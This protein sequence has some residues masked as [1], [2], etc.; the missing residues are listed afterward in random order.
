MKLPKTIQEKI[1]TQSYTQD[2]IGMSG[3]TILLFDTMVLKI[4]P[5]SPE[6][7]T[8]YN[9]LHWLGGRLPV[10]DIL[11]HEVVDGTSYLLMSRLSGQMTCDLAIL[12]DP[13]RLVDLLCEGL[14]MLWKVDISDCPCDATLDQHLS[15]AEYR[16]KNGLVDMDN[17]EPDTFG[18][19]GFQN[20]EELLTWLK[21]NRP[22]EDIVL[23]HGDYCLP[24]IFADDTGVCGFL[25]LGRAGYAD[26]YR[27][28]A[29]CYRSLK[30]NLHGS[31][32]D[33]PPIDFDANALFRKLG[34]TPDWDKIRYYILLDELF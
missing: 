11:C 9:M 3:A 30:S 19:N 20:P 6:A 25:D 32:G 34:I 28:I 29:L 18:E 15:A 26:R 13:T 22:T 31:Y 12:N 16:V 4:R 27:D 23:S 2:T 8:E 24:N 21:A 7:R 5:D 10:P 33:H 14:Q 1:G 17:A